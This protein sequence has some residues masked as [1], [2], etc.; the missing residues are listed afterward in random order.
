[1]ENFRY[2]LVILPLLVVGCSKKAKLTLDKFGNYEVSSKD[3]FVSDAEIDKWRV[4]PLRRQRVSKGIRIGVTLPKLDM[5]DLKTLIRSTEVDSYILRLKRRGV[6]GGRVI[7]H[8][9]IPFLIKKGKTESSFRAKQMTKGYFFVYYSSAALS[10][11]FENMSC[12]AFNHSL[13]IK[14]VS[15]SPHREQLI[16]F[17]VSKSAQERLSVKVEPFDY[18]TVFNGGS[19]LLGDYIVELAY[20]NYEKKERKSSW[21]ELPERV[22]ISREHDTAIKGCSGNNLPPPLEDSGDPVKKFKF[23]R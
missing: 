9:Y 16:K 14:D 18:K 6:V 15:I 12:P 22:T 4:G 13:L 2:F 23:G 10:S 3:V 11:R 8:L 17:N 19:S 7:G 5:G 21:V 1:M 20:F